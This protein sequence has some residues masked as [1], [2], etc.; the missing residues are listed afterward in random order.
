M[1]RLGVNSKRFNNTDLTKWAVFMTVISKL[2]NNFTQHHQLKLHGVLK[3][4]SIM[5]KS[6]TIS[7]ESLKSDCI[8]LKRL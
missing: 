8:E 3:T 7:V 5:I 6:S 2:V 1:S 4:R